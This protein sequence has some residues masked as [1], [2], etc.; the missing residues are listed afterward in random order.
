MKTLE[1]AAEWFLRCDRAILRGKKIFAKLPCANPE[2]PCWVA[3]HR[4]NEDGPW[5]VVDGPIPEGREIAVWRKV[6]IFHDH[7]YPD[8]TDYCSACRSRERLLRHLRRLKR[9]R[10]GALCSLRAAWR[11][12]K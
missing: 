2:K 5:V 9:M 7:L 8:I 11:R 6:W 12:E 1:E 4:G 3:H 10:A